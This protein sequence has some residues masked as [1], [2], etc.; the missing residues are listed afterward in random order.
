M[1]CCTLSVSYFSSRINYCSIKCSC[2]RRSPILGLG[3]R[4]R[5]SYN[6]PTLALAR[7]LSKEC[8]S[9][10]SS[11]CDEES[12]Y[13]HSIDLEAITVVLVSPASCTRFSRH[14]WIGALNF[15]SLCR[16]IRA[17][18][19]P[20]LGAVDDAPDRSSRKVSSNIGSAEASIGTVRNRYLWKEIEIT[21]STS[22]YESK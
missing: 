6:T 9:Q 5:C 7:V 21:N 8:S 15:S 20:A 22:L 14:K 4:S 1:Y 11:I 19:P 10:F 16:S 13:R 17:V 12:R 18:A 2:R 3:R